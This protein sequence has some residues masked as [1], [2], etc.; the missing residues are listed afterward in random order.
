MS[1]TIKSYMQ[2]DAA[3]LQPLSVKR[4]FF[5]KSDNK[6][7][8]KCLPIS[9][10]NVV[11]WGI[12]FP[13]DI[14]FIWGGELENFTQHVKILS[15]ED[16]VTV[17]ENKTIS[18]NT[19]FSL[20]TEK[21]V[22][23]FIMPVPNQFSQE[24]ATVSAIFSTSFYHDTIQPAITILQPNKII[25]IEAG[26]PVATILPISLSELNGSIVKQFNWNKKDFSVYNEDYSKAIKDSQSAEGLFNFYRNGWNHKKEK[27]G[28]HEVKYLDLKTIDGENNV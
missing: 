18:F 16:Y 6:S 19:Y 17:M 24:W 9:S 26:T 23:T 4:D 1:Y 15:G 20:S 13:E 14:S 2:E 12:S 27:I 10:A 3:I 21:G 25:T 5:D 8:Y 11:G 22:S 7:A 28:S